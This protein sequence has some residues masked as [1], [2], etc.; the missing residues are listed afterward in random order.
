MNRL[1]AILMV[2]LVLTACGTHHRKKPKA[3]KE[4]ERYE[5]L[6][7]DTVKLRPGDVV[8]RRGGGL[9][10]HVVVNADR[11]GQY[12]HVGI[13]VDSAGQ[14]LI[15]HAV[16][17][18]HDFEGDVDR[19]KANTPQQYFSTEYTSIGEVLRP[20]DS[21]VGRNA[22]EVAWRVYQRH[23]LFDHDYDDSDTTRMYCTELVAFAYRQAGHDIDEG[24]KHSVN[25]PILQ[26]ECLFPSD[27]YASDFLTTVIHF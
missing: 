12:S 9:T 7:P 15:V 2:L 22:A 19:V 14:M 24:R 27:I 23:T 18:E 6:L 11:E 4:R 26:G 16:P 21:V 13:V 1:T 25:L 10:S 8:F 5:C 17:G 20:A 3:N